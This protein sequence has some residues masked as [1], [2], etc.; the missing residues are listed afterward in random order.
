ML[1]HSARHKE[2]LHNDHRGEAL[3]LEFKIKTLREVNQQVTKSRAQGDH[4]DAGTVLAI[5][6]LAI[7][8]RMWGDIN[9]FRLHWRAMY[10]IIDARGGAEAFTTDELMYT[11][12]LWNCFALL[13][14]R[15]GYF[16]CP[17]NTL[18]PMANY[19]FD[20][21]TKSMIENCHFFSQSFTDRRTSIL[22]L[23][24]NSETELLLLCEA[25]P[26]RVRAFQ[27]GTAIHQALRK[28]SQKSLKPLT[29]GDLVPNRSIKIAG[30]RL[31]TDNCRLA[32]IIYLNLLLLNIGDCSDF[33]EDFLD[34]LEESLTRDKHMIS[35]EYLLWTLLRAPHPVT[36]KTSRE[37]WAR[38]IQ[39]MAV[40]KR[41]R[42]QSVICYQEVMF[43]F[44]QLP[45]NAVELAPSF[46][47]NLCGIEDEAMC[48]G[49]GALVDETSS[50]HAVGNINDNSESAASQIYCELM[51]FA[52]KS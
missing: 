41:A 39:I 12:V 7:A 14:A 51:W 42:Y 16:N 24:P 29:V 48:R 33:T 6:Q 28:A 43:L 11:K 35:P 23:Q 44:L 10:D 49:P 4:P 52:Q 19:D 15:D 25:Y 47:T 34:S 9:T 5:Y 26:R 17:S 22:R 31:R 40:V 46:K 8:E 21:P 36:L 27:P 2:S 50:R 45:T 1:Y 3:S 18:A 30:D 37:L 38:V 20:I 32:C 13:N